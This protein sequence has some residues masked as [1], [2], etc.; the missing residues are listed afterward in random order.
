MKA[1]A[2][3]GGGRRDLF[4]FYKVVGNWKERK[5]TS[6]QSAEVLR[7]VMLNKWTYLHAV[8]LIGAWSTH[9]APA[10][11][12]LSAS[13]IQTTCRRFAPIYNHLLSHFPSN[14]LL[15]CFSDPTAVPGAHLICSFHSWLTRSG[16]LIWPVPPRSAGN[17]M[18]ISRLLILPGRR[19]PMLS[20]H[21][22]RL[23][24][25]HLHHSWTVLRGTQDLFFFLNI[26]CLCVQE[27]AFMCARY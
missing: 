4:F 2:G 15:P 6:Q 17:A 12:M 20:L 27:F 7:E 24:S 5:L 26:L 11:K 14:I 22:C 13:M 1:R 18:C 10:N 16:C 3:G 19:Q 9:A 23:R 25:A 8:V 21:L